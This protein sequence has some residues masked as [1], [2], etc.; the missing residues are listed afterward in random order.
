[1]QSILKFLKP[2]T[3]AKLIACL[4]ALV[5]A[6]GH[7]NWTPS[8]QQKLNVALAT[9][10]YFRLTE[11]GDFTAAYALLSKDL[12][13]TISLER[14]SIR[15]AELNARM[16]EVVERSIRNITWG[17][18]P[19]VGGSAKVFAAVDH[20]GK[21]RHADIHCG[22]LF[23]QQQADGSFKLL[24]EIENSIDKK[25]QSQMTTEQLATARRKIRC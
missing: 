11:R 15:Q 23:W 18:E 1:M 24:H 16:G 2:S 12:Q 8:E 22:K 13:Q 5:G 25:T 21:F 6:Q 3:F 10:Q 7:N 9:Q 19:G 14:W 17:Q 20:S 4:P